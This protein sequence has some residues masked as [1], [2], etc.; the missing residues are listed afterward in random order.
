MKRFQK[1]LAVLPQDHDGAPLLEWAN[2]LAHAS[3]ADCV[4]LIQCLPVPLE[5]FPAQEQEVPNQAEKD[6]FAEQTKATLGDIPF[7]IHASDAPPLGPILHRLAEGEYDLVI[8]AA[9]DFD[10]RALAERMA[11]KSPVGVLVIPGKTPVPPRRILASI[12]YADLSELVLDWSQAFSTLNPEDGCMLEAVHLT[13]LASSA[14]AT[15]AISPEALKKMV[16]DTERENLTKYIQEHA[17]EPSK[18][19]CTLETG[20][21]FGKEI[22]NLGDAQKGDLL[23]IGC[24]GRNALS[25]AFLGSQAAEIVRNSECPVLV[26]K[27]KN[28][29]LGLLRQLLGVGQ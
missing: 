11:R 6:S 19:R 25:V 22:S 17:K 13:R 15:M 10:G 7:S 5:V 23:V 21:S 29:S 20:Y 12:D 4:D 18:W 24:Q 9:S 3:R 14:R 2:L 26:V 8:I 1:I 27:K 16:L 28:A